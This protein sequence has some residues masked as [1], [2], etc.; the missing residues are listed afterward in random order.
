MDPITILIFL[1]S[2]LFTL[3]V[4]TLIAIKILGVIYKPT[5]DTVGK[6]R[7][8]MVLGSGGHTTEILKL[9]KCLN[10]QTYNQRLYFVA[11]TD[12]FSEK[13]LEQLENS[14]MKC[15]Q[16][17]RIPRSREVGQSYLT[18]ALSTLLATCH[19]LSPLLLF[20]PQLLI[21]N[22]PG[23][24]LPVTLICWLLS[25]LRISPCKIIFVESLCRVRS[26][27]LTGKILQYV[28][29]EVLVQWQ[30]LVS[31]YPRTKYIGKFL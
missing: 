20:Q 30:E 21:V 18:S 11:E 19:C 9:L 22:G 3:V 1:F 24:C 2:A 12:N 8:C 26:L 5:S 7:L 23:T 16:I 31:K 14:D 13:K 25:C 28:A 29:D 10:L 6:I 15:F 4:G 17:V 27:S